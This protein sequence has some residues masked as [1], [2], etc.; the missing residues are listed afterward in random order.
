MRKLL[1]KV[2]ASHLFVFVLGAGLATAT[3]AQAVP[4]PSAQAVADRYAAL[5]SFAQALSLIATSH[6]DVVDERKLLYG[7]IVGMVSEL[8]PHSAFYTPSQYTRLREDTEGEFGG[9]GLALG[10]AEAKLHPIVES[11]IP[12]SPAARAG[13]LVG[14]A[15]I[16]IDGRATVSEEGEESSTQEWHNRLR[17]AV[18]TRLAIKLVRKGWP[19][20]REFTLVRE[21]IAVPS[22]EHDRFG[23]VAYVAIERFREATT[24][25]LH[26][27][28]AVLLGSSDMRLILD[29]R[30][31]P[32]GLLDKGISVADTFLDE[33]VIVSVVSRGG[34]N[35]EVARAHRENSYVGFPMVVL[36]DQN[37]ASASE[38]VA[39]ALQDLGRATIIG[40]PTYGKGSVQTFLDLKDGS[41]LKLTTSRYLTPKGRTLEE[42]GISPD[43]EVEAF[44]ADVIRPSGAGSDS[45]AVAKLHLPGLSKGQRRRL[46]Q[47]P[48]LLKSY[49]YLMGG[50]ATGL[51]P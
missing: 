3:L 7:G 22:V 6:V 34:R 13:L 36:V 27:A 26:I 9:V 18:G 14:D 12:D 51:T 31:N 42:R 8:D 2:S 20:P 48:Q 10:A 41:G 25:D 40:V 39:G 11:V 29:L 45:P 30:G 37:S 23:R 46:A 16:E 1:T 5:D 43:I 44:A 32:G 21:R 19:K 4:K 50:T 33:G 15:L 35:V 28:L 17:G 38:I 24:R 49:Q 47:D